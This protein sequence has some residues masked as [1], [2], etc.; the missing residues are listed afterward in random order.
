LGGM[1]FIGDGDGGQG[2]SPGRIEVNSKIG[3][4]H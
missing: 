4:H 1:C 2:K 3:A